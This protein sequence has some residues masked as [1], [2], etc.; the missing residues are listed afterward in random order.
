MRI[1]GLRR[2]GFR[3]MAPY[4]TLVLVLALAACGMDQV[5]VPQLDGPSEMAV[6]VGMT[7]TPDVMTADGFS[8]S[9]IVAT[10]RGPNAE[11]LAGRDIFFTITDGAGNAANI[12]ELHSL[13]TGTTVGTGLQVRTNA[14]GVA[15]VVYEAP[16]RSDATANFTVLVIARPVGNDA[17]AANYRRVRIELRSAESRLFPEVSSNK[18]PICSFAVQTTGKSTCTA[19]GAIISCSIPV[20]TSVLFQST[21]SDPDGFIVRYQWYFGNGKSADHAD[22][23]TSYS[24]PGAYTV[25]HLVTDNNGA[26]AACAASFLVVP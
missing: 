23:S 6:S 20:N 11:P 12:G 21:A 3:R 7:A 4:A 1:H 15:A 5:H 8:T 16:A 9:L 13:E 25:T 22:V 17:N 24:I 14:Q 2:W 18:P 10:V 19:A 26:F